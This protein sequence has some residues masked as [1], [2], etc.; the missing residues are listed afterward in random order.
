MTKPRISI[1]GLGYVGAVSAGCFAER[2]HDVVGVDVADAKVA[3][4]ASGRSPIME[5]GLEELLA[6]H[7]KSGRL[8]A[9]GDADFAI[10]ATDVSLICVGTPSMA[11]GTPDVSAVSRVCEQI[12]RALKGKRDQHLVVLRSTTLPWM[13]DDLFCPTLE[14]ESG[15]RAGEGFGFAVHP[16]FLREGSA[17]HDFFHPP[18]T[19]IGAHD[20]A[21]ARAIA[22]LYDGIAAPLQVT[23]PAIA[24]MVKYTDNTFHAL[25]VAFANEI[26]RVCKKWDIDAQEVMSFVCQDTKLNI[27]P[28][29]LRPAFA[30]GGSCLPKDVRA[31]VRQGGKS[32]ASLPLLSEILRSNDAHVLDVVETVRKAGAARVGMFGVTFKSG[33]DDLRESAA[34]RVAQRLADDGCEVLIHDPRVSVD[35]L[36]GA[37]R[38]YVEQQ[39]PALSQ[40]MRTSAQEVLDKADVI[41]V[42]D[43]D[44]DWSWAA[45]RLRPEQTIIDVE[46]PGKRVMGTDPRY[47]GICW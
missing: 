37:N 9:T 41:I 22:E 34:A 28:A 16:E 45:T 25:K 31:L 38:Q 24:M 30:F 11:D 21:A 40:M 20:P 3:L 35:R 46:G 2:G 4:L 36:I 18:K 29:Y 13:A 42:T 33:T 44:F 47:V 17:V 43:A 5:A 10:A 26:G 7:A 19:V 39:I 27:S 12:G 32:G 1:F 14:R 6:R 23:T 8:T 15:K